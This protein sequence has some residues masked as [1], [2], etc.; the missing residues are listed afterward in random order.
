[1][2]SAI[3][4]VW[5]I[6]VS[7]VLCSKIPREAFFSVD[8]IFVFAVVLIYCIFLLAENG[9]TNQCLN[10]RSKT[11]VNDK[12][13]GVV[14]LIYISTVLIMNINSWNFSSLHKLSQPLL[15]L[16]WPQALSGP[17]AKVPKAILSWYHYWVM[18]LNHHRKRALAMMHT[19]TQNHYL[20]PLRDEPRLI[21]SLGSA[22]FAR[23]A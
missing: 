17:A 11:N 5:N 20:Q 21:W 15:A 4:V 12:F 13:R 16:E 22:Y 8:A 19:L 6:A 3:E 7:L 1:M 14:L 2:L 23:E 18:V 9:H 10:E